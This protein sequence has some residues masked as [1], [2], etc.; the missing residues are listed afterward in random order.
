MEDTMATAKL[1][2][3]PYEFSV[4]NGIDDC[5]SCVPPLLVG[6]PGTLRVRG[7]QNGGIARVM[8]VTQKTSPF[9]SRAYPSRRS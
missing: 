8:F 2:Q 4:N 3:K 7:T 1:S 6:S 5:E 9:A